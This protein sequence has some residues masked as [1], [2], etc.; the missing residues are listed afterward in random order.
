MTKTRDYF[1][2][3]YKALLIIFV[4]IGHFVQPCVNNNNLLH[5][6]KLL[7]YAFHMPA[8]I[9]VSGYFSKK[10]APLNK[11]IQKVLIPYLSFELIY[12]CFYTYVIGKE[13]RIA[14]LYPKFSLWYLLALFIWKLI[15]PYVKKIPHYMVITIALGLI[16][17]L[18]PVK[19]SFL[20]ISRVCV[21]YP[22]FLAGTLFTKEQITPYQNKR[23]RMISTALIGAFVL[24][25]AF[26]F[27]AVGFSNLIFHGRY[28]Y[29]TMHQGPIE[30]MLI[31]LLA[32]GIGFFLTYA[33]AILIPENKNVFSR[34]GEATMAIYLFH[35]LTFKYLDD[36]TDLIDRVNTI[37]ETLL[38]FALCVGLAFFFSLKPFQSFVNIF[39]N[40]K[41]PELK[42]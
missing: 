26:G 5:T 3:N 19:G 8:F 20:S 1:F 10:N 12:Y 18:L 30:G 29:V 25:L 34:L 13:T 35:G 21:F 36:C 42:K 6:V 11:L 38:F 15:T 27:E 4:I 14:L 9:F 33:F 40:V 7:I 22:Y 37:P 32:Y 23:G 39:S 24:F 31:R 2:D 16:I 28:R 41:I 17:G